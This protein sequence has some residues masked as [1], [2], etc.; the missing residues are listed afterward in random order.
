M[1]RFD[2]IV[3][4]AGVSGA[5]TAIALARAGLQVALIERKPP[6]ASVLNPNA[7]VV[8]LAPASVS[9][10]QRLS[11]WPLPNVSAAAYTRMQV[12]AG[13]HRLAFDAA[14]VG[15]TA[16]GWI[17]DLEV[18][19][20][21]CWQGL[22]PAVRVFAPAE[23][24]HVDRGRDDVRVEL[25][26]GQRLRARLLV[27]AEG[28]RSQWRQRLGFNIGER[29]YAA[30]GVVAQVRCEHANPGIAFQRFGVGGPLALLPLADG[31]SS[32]VW[33]RPR[34]QAEQWLHA[35]DDALCA[36]LTTASDARFGRVLEVSARAQFPLRMA[37]ADRF[38]FDRV[39]LIG[40]TAHVVHPLAGLGL[41]LGL[42]DVAAL[43]DVITHAQSKSRDIGGVGSL[44]RY[45]AWREGDTRIAAGLIDA[46]ERIFGAEASGFQSIAER[47]VGIVD[48]LPMLKRF[49]SMQAAGWG[50][51][52]PSLALPI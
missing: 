40:D 4:G 26:D 17:T 11:L 30:S 15:T 8:A 1:S 20:Q 46:I 7:R 6:S 39:A 16:L 3:S 24:A 35:D 9:F 22:A 27:L 2:V 14:D 45:S 12:E 50:G 48:G 43:I 34:A 21:R 10:L 5:V 47:A 31:R 18:L 44:A 19:Q 49:F 23:I 13:N 41:N 52:I 37:M 38:A 33:T 42:L 29:D 36:A 28:A 32:I 25:D 51:R